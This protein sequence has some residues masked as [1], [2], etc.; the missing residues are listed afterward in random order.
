M[1]FSFP[2]TAFVSV[3]PP[4]KLPTFSPVKLGALTNCIAKVSDTST[5]HSRIQFLAQITADLLRPFTRQEWKEY[6]K[7]VTIR[8]YMGRLERSKKEFIKYLLQCESPF[9]FHSTAIGNYRQY[10]AQKLRIIPKIYPYCL[11]DICLSS[12]EI[13]HLIQRKNQHVSTHTDIDWF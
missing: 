8:W 10:T 9:I 2:G 5:R 4:D 12:E 11:P 13:R 1:L 3:N 6:R 7:H